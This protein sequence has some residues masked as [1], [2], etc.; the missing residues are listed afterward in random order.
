MSCPSAVHSLVTVSFRPRNGSCGEGTAST[1]VYVSVR[2]GQHKHPTPRLAS[3]RRLQR[4]G[5]LQLCERTQPSPGIIGAL[6]DKQHIALFSCTGGGAEHTTIRR[7]KEG[8]VWLMPA[9]SLAQKGSR[10]IQ[11]PTTVRKLV[12]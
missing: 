8:L 12:D 1:G 3:M 6:A 10:E 7:A 2:G 9:D 4:Y 5:R 11:R